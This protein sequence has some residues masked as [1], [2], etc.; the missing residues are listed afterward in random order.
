MKRSILASLLVLGCSLSAFAAPITYNVN[1]TIGTG[2]IVGS[3]ETDGTLGVLST[4]NILD[5][6]GLR[7]P[8]PI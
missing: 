3:I 6:T 7:C 1:H 2:S 4:T 5:W 8:R